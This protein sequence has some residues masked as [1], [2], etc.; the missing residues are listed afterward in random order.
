MVSVVGM[1]EVRWRGV[2]REREEEESGWGGGGGGGGGA[3][4]RSA[5]H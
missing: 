3:G 4:D 1:E 2:C 5:H